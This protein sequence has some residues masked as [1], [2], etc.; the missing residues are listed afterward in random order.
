M[1][2]V[3]AFVVVEGVAA[4]VA[5]LLKVDTGTL[6]AGIEKREAVERCL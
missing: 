4:A 5:I 6:V 2:V 3:E 1:F